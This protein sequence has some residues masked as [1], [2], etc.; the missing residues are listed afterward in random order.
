MLERFDGIQPHHLLGLSVR[1]MVT[2]PVFVGVADG[3]PAVRDGMI[4]LA[5][6][7]G[8]EWVL[9][10]PHENAARMRFLDACESAGF[11]PKVRHYT[12]DAVTARAMVEAGCVCMA[13]PSFRSSGGVSAFPLR[14]DPLRAEVLFAMRANDTLDPTDR[15]FHCAALAYRAGVAA[16]PHFQRWWDEH[17][18]EHAE[19]DAAITTGANTDP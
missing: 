10:P 7:A 15:F 6:L 11:T 13:A 3:H 17:P 19:L 2:E 8:C 5:D 9:P 14:G 12:S 18:Q 16:N 4:D 1:T